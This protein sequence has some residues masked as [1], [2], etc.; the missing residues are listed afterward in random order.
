MLV[1]FQSD[2]EGVHE[3]YL[4]VRS[5]GAVDLYIPMAVLVKV[6]TAVDNISDAEATPCRLLF[7]EGMLYIRAADGTRY[8]LLGQP[9]PAW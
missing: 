6:N 4:R 2:Q 1:E 9:L 5:R 8:T 7:R 3:A